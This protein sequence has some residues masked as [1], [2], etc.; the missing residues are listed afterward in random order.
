M[1]VPSVFA[2]VLRTLGKEISNYVCILIN[3]MVRIFVSNELF[4]Y[5]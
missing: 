4:S 5:L 3:I 1:M 2:S